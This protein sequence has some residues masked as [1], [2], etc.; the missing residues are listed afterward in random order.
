MC[1]HY[2]SVSNTIIH[3][4]CE[5]NH[6]FMKWRNATRDTHRTRETLSERYILNFYYYNI[7]NSVH[8]VFNIYVYIINMLTG[9]TMLYF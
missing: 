9:N 7:L 5:I 8:V 6:V 4:K 2:L 1:K 3:R